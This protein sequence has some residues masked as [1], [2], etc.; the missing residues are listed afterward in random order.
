MDAW[1]GDNDF[2]DHSVVHALPKGD[3]VATVAIAQVI[4]GYYCHGNIATIC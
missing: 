1:R 4:A 2:F 3:D